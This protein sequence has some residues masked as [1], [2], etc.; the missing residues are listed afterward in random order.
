MIS[1]CYLLVKFMSTSTQC[2]CLFINV[3]T[4]PLPSYC[5]FHCKIVSKFLANIFCLKC[6]V[7]GSKRTNIL[8]G[9]FSHF[10]KFF[11]IFRGDN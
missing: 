2:Q 11:D 8:P 6:W 10:Q 9:T 5:S 3:G 4:F 7:V 1:Q